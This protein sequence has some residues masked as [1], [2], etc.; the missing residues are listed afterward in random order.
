MAEFKALFARRP[1]APESVW[2][3]PR[4]PV[5]SGPNTFSVSRGPPPRPR[6][7]TMAGHVLTVYNCGTN[8]HQDKHDVVANLNRETSSAR[9]IND[10]VGSGNFIGGRKNPGTKNILGGLIVGSGA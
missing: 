5:H 3:Q 9:H 4:R 2:P 10:G 7:H 6:S 1:A 8:Y